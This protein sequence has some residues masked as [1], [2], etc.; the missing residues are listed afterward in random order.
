MRLLGLA[1]LPMA[2]PRSSPDRNGAI[3]PCGSPQRRHAGHRCPRLASLLQYHRLELGAVLS[4]AWP[5]DVREAPAVAPSYRMSSEAMQMHQ[6]LN[7]ATTAT[8]REGIAFLILTGE[9]IGFLPDH[10]AATWVE[11]GMLV[12][13]GYQGY[14]FSS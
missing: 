7:C 12:P 5:L 8:D 1:M 2:S 14:E 13:L 6:E 9:Y 10:F 3:Q 4:A 11:R